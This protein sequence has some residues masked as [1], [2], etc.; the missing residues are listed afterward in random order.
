[1]LLRAD[2]AVML[3]T[4]K[5]KGRPFRVNYTKV[6]GWGK[7]VKGDAHLNYKLFQNRMFN[8]LHTL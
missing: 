4:G 3:V 6:V 2:P 1:M 5:V 7:Q 8:F